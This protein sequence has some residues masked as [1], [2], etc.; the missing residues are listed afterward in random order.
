MLG[1]IQMDVYM[2]ICASRAAIPQIAAIRYCPLHKNRIRDPPVRYL[3]YVLQCIESAVQDA[4]SVMMK[5][6]LRTKRYFGGIAL[7]KLIL[8]YGH[9]L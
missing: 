4:L 2:N 6:I 5:G 9:W 1:T 7:T 3:G 8:F